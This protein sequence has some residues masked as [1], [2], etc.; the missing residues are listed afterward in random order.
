[1]KR[2]GKSTFRSIDKFSMLSYWL[3]LLFFVCAPK[4]K[5]YIT[6]IQKMLP[7]VTRTDQIYVGCEVI[8][9][10]FLLFVPF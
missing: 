4:K 3:K 6:C 8:S 5:I 10:K 1:M 2:P 7:A 9:N